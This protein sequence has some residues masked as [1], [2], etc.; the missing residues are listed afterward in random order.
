MPPVSHD[1]F[2]FAPVHHLMAMVSYVRARPWLAAQ[3]DLTRLS[4]KLPVASGIQSWIAIWAMAVGK[5]ALRAEWAAEVW[6]WAV[7]GMGA[8]MG[9]RFAPKCSALLHAAPPCAF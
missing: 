6:G 4:P 5:F 1:R 9:A 7:S 2:V 3:T 8:Q